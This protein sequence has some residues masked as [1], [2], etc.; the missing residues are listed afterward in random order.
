[1]NW[2]LTK[3]QSQLFI[4]MCTF[5]ALLSHHCL[6]LNTFVRSHLCTFLPQN[7]FSPEQSI[8]KIF[9]KFWLVRRMLWRAC[10]IIGEWKICNIVE[11]HLV[12][13][14]LQCWRQFSCLDTEVWWKKG[15]FLHLIARAAILFRRFILH[16]TTRELLLRTW[17]FWM[18]LLKF[19]HTNQLVKLCV[20]KS[21]FSGLKLSNLVC[22]RDGFGVCSLYCA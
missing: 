21:K 4:C 1:M 17:F 10:N 13:S 20:K 16:L 19:S 12:E 9:H 6:R 8:M 2:F 11:M 3:T 14:D 5:I 18:S 7:A 22:T 15:E